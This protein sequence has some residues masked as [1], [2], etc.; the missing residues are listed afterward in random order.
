MYLI[1]SLGVLNLH[2]T[3]AEMWLDLEGVAGPGLITS[4]HRPGDDG[5]H[6]QMPV[7]GIDRRV[8]NSAIGNAL[9]EWVNRKWEYD[10]DRPEFVC[11]VFH[12]VNTHG[13]H[14][15][16]QCHSNTRRR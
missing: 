16:L 2:P 5:V 11:A 13:W 9:K 1:K 12:K 6:G 15:H 7:R 8:R 10:P 3:L 4:A 14:L